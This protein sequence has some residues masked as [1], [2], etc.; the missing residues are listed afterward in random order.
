MEIARDYLNKLSETFE[1][2]QET[3]RFTKDILNEF[4]RNNKDWNDSNIGNISKTTNARKIVFI[5][6]SNRACSIG[7]AVKILGD[8]FSNNN[9]SK[10]QR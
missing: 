7:V 8:P 4:L 10:I 1:V 2:S 3:I 5:S 9:E 6:I